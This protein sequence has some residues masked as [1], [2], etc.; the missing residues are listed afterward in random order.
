MRN[1]NY[2]LTVN[3]N[4]GI[5]NTKQTEIKMKLGGMVDYLESVTKVQKLLM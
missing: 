4:Q 1:E 3:N 5:G 2:S